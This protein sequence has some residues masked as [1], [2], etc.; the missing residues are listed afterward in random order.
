[1]CGMA[2]ILLGIGENKH[3]MSASSQSTCPQPR[4][5]LWFVRCHRSP[6]HNLF[7][8]LNIDPHIVE[9]ISPVHCRPNYTLTF[10]TSIPPDK[11]TALAQAINN[12][13]IKVSIYCNGSRYKGGIG[14][15]T[16]LYINSMEK[17]SLQYHLDPDTEHTV[18]EAEIT[19][20]LL[21]LHLLSSLRSSPHSPVVIGS[22]SQA[23][24]HVLMNQRPHPAHH[25]LDHVHTSA[26]HLHATHYK[27]RH[28]STPLSAKQL[29]AD[30]QCDI[31][32]LQIHWTS[33]HVDFPSNK[34]ADVITKSLPLVRPVLLTF[35]LLSSARNPSCIAS[36]HSAILTSLSS[37]SNGKEDGRDPHTLGLLLT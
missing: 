32:D 12:H 26:E 2:V 20:L 29:H 19:G 25:L 22:D 23:T 31:L 16:V 34:H 7:G 10:I 37:V 9:S 27:L 15:S 3:E 28:P 36:W 24:I 11:P 14:A 18:Y 35:S 21:A 5:N 8:L 33:G 17:C 1:M 6:L 13:N 4:Y 30:Y